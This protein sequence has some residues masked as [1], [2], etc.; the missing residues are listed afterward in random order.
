MFGLTNLQKLF[1][2]TFLPGL[3]NSDVALVAGSSSSYSYSA[4][5]S[6]A[7]CHARLAERIISAENPQHCNVSIYSF[8]VL[9]PDGLQRSRGRT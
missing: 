1:C 8:P 6:V 7:H 4:S 2:K 9:P 3:Y 5:L